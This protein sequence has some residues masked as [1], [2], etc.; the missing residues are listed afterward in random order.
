MLETK[1][2]GNAG[3]TVPKS[4]PRELDSAIIPGYQ[5]PYSAQE[6]AV[7]LLL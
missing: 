3:A 5:N 2:S 7:V 1:F 4:T 6:N